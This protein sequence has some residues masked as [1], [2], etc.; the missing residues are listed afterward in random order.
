[1]YFEAGSITRL[2]VFRTTACLLLDQ[3]GKGLFFFFWLLAVDFFFF[4]FFKHPSPK[5]LATDFFP[6]AFFPSCFSSFLFCVFVGRLVAEWVLR[7]G[8]RALMK[9]GQDSGFWITDYNTM[10]WLK[11]ADQ[12]IRP[13]SELK[14]LEVDFLNVDSVKDMG[15]KRE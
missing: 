10:P 2:T 9:G 1:M 7:M 3:I 6:S 8:G 15:L 11:D 14:L 4:F 5:S 12:G 13:R